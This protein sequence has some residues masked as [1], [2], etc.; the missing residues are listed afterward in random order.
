MIP[1]RGKTVSAVSS[2]SSNA[3]GAALDIGWERALELRSAL[4]GSI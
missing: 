2:V 1:D 4:G 3:A